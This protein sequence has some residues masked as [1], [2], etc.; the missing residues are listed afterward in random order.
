[1][2]KHNTQGEYED[3]EDDEEDES[4]GIEDDLE[5]HLEQ[6]LEKALDSELSDSEVTIPT[7]MAGI[8]QNDVEGEEVEITVDEN[9]N[10]II[11]E[12]R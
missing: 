9:G 2:D 4:D 5:L 12:E 10:R 1:M 7:L 3:D 8:L 6:E 11:S